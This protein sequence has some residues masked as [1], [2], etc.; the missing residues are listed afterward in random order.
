MPAEWFR[1]WGD[2]VH[3]TTIGGE[4]NEVATL[5]CVPAIFSNLLSALLAFAGLTA[6]LMFLVGSL[7][8]MN[9]HGDAKK[10]AGAE[11]NFKFGIIGLAIVLTSFLLINII[12]QITGVECITKFGFGCQ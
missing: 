6:L 2:C 3:R 12:S 1:G 9:S 5:S 8:F 7:K 10:L 4:V 11:N